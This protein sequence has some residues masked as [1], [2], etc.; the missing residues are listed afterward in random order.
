MGNN[1]KTKKRKPTKPYRF[2]NN[3]RSAKNIIK[4]KLKGGEENNV[5]PNEMFMVYSD[6]NDENQNWAKLIIKGKKTIETR[7]Y[8]P[9][10]GKINKPLFL[11]STSISEPDD[12]RNIHD[13]N[14]QCK[15][16]GIIKIIEDIRYDEKEHWESDRELHMVPSENRFDFDPNRKIQDGEALK[17]GWRIEVIQDFSKYES[18]KYTYKNDTKNSPFY[19]LKSNSTTNP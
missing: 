3:K 17:H 7:N 8:S 11:I 1:E 15:I 10:K 9:P 14:P 4:R 2:K 16:L 5:I 13:Q 12:L 18:I 6:I 19:E